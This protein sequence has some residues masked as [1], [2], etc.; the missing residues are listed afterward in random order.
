MARRLLD[1]DALAAFNKEATTLHAESNVNFGKSLQALAKHVFPKYALATQKQWFRRSVHKKPGLR[2]REWLARLTEINEMLPEF[3][4]NFNDAQKIPEDELKDIVEFGVPASWRTVWVQHDFQPMQR[5]MGE[6]VDFCEQIEYAEQINDAI[7][8]KNNNKGPRAEVDQNGGENNKGASVH[9]NKSSSQ[10]RGKN[11]KNERNKHTSYADSDGR[12]G[13]A[14][15]SNATDHTTAECR[16]IMN[17]VG[18][19]RAQ[20]EANPRPQNGN[21][22]QK[23][24]NNNNNKGGNQS[25]NNGDFHTLLEKVEKVKEGLERAMKQQQNGNGKRKQRE[26][27]KNVSFAKSESEESQDDNFNPDSFHL[28]LEQLSISDDPNDLIGQNE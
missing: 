9:A 15:H 1:G 28:E 19:M 4:P 7:K 26:N 27:E 8:G 16:V 21:K 10:G 12:D 24:N 6:I 20:W 25:K 17:Q 2:T 22:R 13:C 23:T 3:P 11:K 5:D 14:L 18:K